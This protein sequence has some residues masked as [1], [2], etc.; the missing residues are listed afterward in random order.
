MKTDVNEIDSVIRPS[1]IVGERLA[2]LHRS[3]SKMRCETDIVPCCKSLFVR[4][5]LY[6]SVPFFNYLC[7]E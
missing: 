2:G 1:C 6:D 3:Y 4:V 5:L 7:M